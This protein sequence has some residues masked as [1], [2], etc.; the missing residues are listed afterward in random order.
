LDQPAQSQANCIIK[1]EISEAGRRSQFLAYATRQQIRL[2]LAAT[3]MRH[4]IRNRRQGADR[5][6][7]V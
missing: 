6:D 7:A 2:F 3:M 1:I 4:R 5:N